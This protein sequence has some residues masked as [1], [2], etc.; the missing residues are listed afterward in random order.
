MK[1]VHAVTGRAYDAR[2][3]WTR[4]GAPWIDA[5]GV[6]RVDPF[7]FEIVEASAAELRDLPWDWRMLTAIEPTESRERND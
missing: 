4:D 2:L 6:G 7:A 5:H 3:V 1:I